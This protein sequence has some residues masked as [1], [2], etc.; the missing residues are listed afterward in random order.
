MADTTP[1]KAETELIQSNGES[2]MENI[3]GYPAN[4]EVVE[5]AEKV[6]ELAKSGS[7]QGVAVAFA[8]APE[9]G[10]KAMAGQCHMTLAST[11]LVMANELSAKPFQQV[12]AKLDE[13]AKEKRMADMKADPD[14]YLAKKKGIILP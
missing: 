5:V 11:C 13:I 4:P 1:S 8:L 3:T 14:A 10:G 6:L 7:I 9:H 12:K 2:D